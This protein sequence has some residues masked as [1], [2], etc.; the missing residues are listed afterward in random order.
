MKTM[1]FEEVDVD[2]G[3]IFT[4]VCE[5]RKPVQI[6]LGDERAIVML[7]LADY[8]SFDETSYLLGS[9]KNAQ[10]LMESIATIKSDAE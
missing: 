10:R 3:S 1:T 2:F 8:I 5:S 4:E 9:P 7:P 6:S